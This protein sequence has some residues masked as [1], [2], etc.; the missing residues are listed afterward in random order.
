MEKDYL[1]LFKIILL[2]NAGLFLVIAVFANAIYDWGTDC[3]RNWGWDGIVDLRERM[4]YW[5]LPFSQVLL[6][7]L[8]IGCIVAVFLLE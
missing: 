6:I 1:M 4:K 3:A 5:A 8:G 2:A 7:L